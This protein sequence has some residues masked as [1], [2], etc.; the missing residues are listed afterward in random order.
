VEAFRLRSLVG[1]YPYLFLDAR[2]EKVRD[3]QS[4]VVS[5]SLVVAYGVAETG[6]REVLGLDVFRSEDYACWKGF[7]RGLA[8]R[9]LSGVKLVVSDA[10]EG[11][12]H[13]PE[14]QCA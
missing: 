5:M 7:L 3:E 12:K 9:G 10:H 8:G 1:R 11:L 14:T 2:N 13:L 6:E 4:R